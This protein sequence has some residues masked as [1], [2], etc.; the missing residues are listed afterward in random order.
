MLEQRTEC[1]ATTSR[2]RQRVEVAGDRTGRVGVEVPSSRS[3]EGV[4][5]GPELVGKPRTQVG[6]TVATGSERDPQLRPSPSLLG[7]QQRRLLGLGHL[8]RHRIEH[9]PAEH[10]Q[11]ARTEVPRIGDQL[12]ARLAGQLRPE[13]GGQRVQGSCDHHR[14]R[15]IEHAVPK[16]GEDDG[17]ATQ[18]LGRPLVTHPD[19]HLRA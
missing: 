16:R 3:G 1:F 17:P 10:P 15:R 11:L 5:V 13:I 9:P 18:R 7:S 2:Q 12:C 19:R 6:D 14:L 4:E 8:G